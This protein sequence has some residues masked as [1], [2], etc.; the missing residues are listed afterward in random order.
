MY[1]LGY[2]IL[3]NSKVEILIDIFSYFTCLRRRS[4]SNI[5]VSLGVSIMII[6]FLKS[7][8]GLERALNI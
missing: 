1:F 7:K 3:W 5:G 8:M 4:R 2:F 6:H